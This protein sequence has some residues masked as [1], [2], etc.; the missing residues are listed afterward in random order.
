MENFGLNSVATTFPFC[1][2]DNLFLWAVHL[3]ERPVMIRKIDLIYEGEKETKEREINLERD[4]T[5]AQRRMK[6]M[7]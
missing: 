2:Q 5:E 7:R 4:S 1:S 3:T 6:R